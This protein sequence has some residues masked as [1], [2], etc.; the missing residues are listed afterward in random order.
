M[1]QV[2]IRTS[3]LA[4]YDFDPLTRLVIGAHEHCIRVCVE[5]S[6]PQ[7]LKIGMWPR[8]RDGSMFERH[9]S[10]EDAIAEWRAAA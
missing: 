8:K 2:N 3:G 1:L 7:Y 4:T 5:P 9:P 6:A 10:I